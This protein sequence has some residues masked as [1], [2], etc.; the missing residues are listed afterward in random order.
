MTDPTPGCG[1]KPL[2]LALFLSNYP[3]R[4][5]SPEYPRRSSPAPPPAP[6]PDRPRAAPA[7]LT[8]SSDSSAYPASENEDADAR[9][10]FAEKRASP[11]LQG[12]LGSPVAN[13]A[14]PVGI[15]QPVQ[16]VRRRPKR[17]LLRQNDAGRRELPRRPPMG[18]S[19]IISAEEMR[20]SLGWL[21]AEDGGR[22]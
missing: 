6:P 1:G 4:P 9:E 22:T 19:A 10:V 18:K 14:K 21:R 3:P 7:P 12:R 13:R 2:L 8:S 5:P 20:P 16:Q 11:G 15:P 17:V